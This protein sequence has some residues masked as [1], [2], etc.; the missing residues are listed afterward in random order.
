M[1]P[2]KKWTLKEYDKETAEAIA[3]ALSVLPVTAILLN[4]RGCNDKKSALS[5][6]NKENT[7][8]HDPFLLPDMK[9]AVLR[10]VTATEKNEKTAVY[11][12]YD[13]DGITGTSLLVTFLRGLGLDVVYHIPDRLIE[14]YGVNKTSIKALYDEGVSLIV[15]V[16]TGI[17]ANE[18]VEYAKELGIDVIITDHHECRPELPDAVAAVDPKRPGCEYPFKD[19]AGV[20]VAFKLICAYNCYM[21]TGTTEFTQDDS[22]IIFDTIRECYKQY[23]DITA[24]GTIADVMPV[25]GENR[26]IIAYGLN[27][28]KKT[29]NKGLTALLKASEL[30]NDSGCGKL[31]SSSV[32]F[33]LAPRIN[34]AGRL[35]Q[36]DRAVDMFLT[37]SDQ[38]ADEAA[39]WLCEKNRERQKTELDIIAEAEEQI[40]E[41]ALKDDTRIIV[42][43]SDTWHHG[44]IGIVSSRLTEKYNLPSILISFKDSDDIGKGSGRS[45]DGFDLLAAI[46][47]SKDHLIKYGGHKSAA[48]LSVHRSE[49]PAFINKISKYAKEHISDED[50]TPVISYDAEL[51]VNDINMDTVTDLSKLEPFGDGNPVPLFMLSDLKITD[52]IPLKEGKHTKINFVKD[53]KVLSGMYFGMNK[54][55]LPYTE[56]DHTDI[57]FTLSENEFRGAVTAQIQIKEMRLSETEASEYEADKNVYFYIKDDIILPEKDHIPNRDDCASV[58]RLIKKYADNNNATLNL[59]KLIKSGECVAGYIKFLLILDIFEELDLLKYKTEDHL[60]ID[61]TLKEP[62]EKK[63]LTD[64]EL[65]AKL[66]GQI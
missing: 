2:R 56:G 3:E 54:D 34:A 17:T 4:E 10:I 20:G 49:L 8:M 35:G 11:G 27:R 5:F 45:I 29:K 18:E 63:P 58:F 44:V 25:I 43:H 62:T 31:S 36:A 39:L 16:D 24:L 61:I 19:L 6:I 22:E 12:D 13:V 37:E 9:E 40:A 41:G 42:L 14:G 53:G 55:E 52:M 46:T 51:T 26:L 21:A 7:A 57:L 23:G 66:N 47:D 48:G 59:H 65:F 28:M 64:S 32:S 38:E 60:M 30:I 1:I 15:T 50:L 33:V